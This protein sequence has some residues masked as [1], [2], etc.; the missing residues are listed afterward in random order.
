MQDLINHCLQYSPINRPSA[1]EVF[2]RLCSSEFV[3]LKRAVQ[4][5]RDQ[6]IQMF[7]TRVRGKG[8]L[9]DSGVQG[10]GQGASLC[11][12]ILYWAT[13]MY[14]IGSTCIAFGL[15]VFCWQ[16]LSGSNLYTIFSTLECYVKWYILPPPPSCS[17]S[18]KVR[19]VRA[20]RCGWPVFWVALPWSPSWTSLSRMLHLMY[21]WQALTAVHPGYHWPYTS[22]WSYV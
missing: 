11:T 7:A 19:V 5:E 17:V 1:Q 15:R 13:C 2:D 22:A 4:V 10:M 12:L 8:L 9:P 21:V 16:I 14:C 20:W 6:T 3:S 18:R